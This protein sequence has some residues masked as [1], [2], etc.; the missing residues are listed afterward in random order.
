MNAP[1]APTPEA[2][3]QLLSKLNLPLLTR[4]QIHALV[5]DPEDGQ[6][7][8]NALEC[9]AGDA[10][11]R[12]WLAGAATRAIN[13]VPTSQKSPVASASNA[14]AALPPI[15][16]PLGPP[17]ESTPARQ[18][19]ARPV[20]TDGNVR[21]LRQPQ[22]P[23]DFPRAGMNGTPVRERSPD[24]PTADRADGEPQAA[25]ELKPVRYDQVNA[26][27]KEYGLSIERGPNP[28]RTMN[29]INIAIAKAVGATAKEGLD[30]KQKIMIMLEPFEI[31][32]I[33]A[34]LFDMLPK[35][36]FAG[37]GAAN[38]KWLE[39]ERN[40]GEWASVRFTLAQDK[41]IRR[42][43]VGYTDAGRVKAIFMRALQ[44]QMRLQAN[45][46]LPI[47]KSTALMYQEQTTARAARR[48]SES[49]RAGAR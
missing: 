41:D 4:A 36:R 23:T 24:H 9:A 22:R 2:I 33:A 34:V 29:T 14:A 37:H 6:H 28:E 30:W 47:V 42:V 43:N 44:D 31:E 46:I 27:G 16:D 1:L 18:N 40:T 35:V 25:R 32:L 8:P 10:S 38:D 21:A 26:Y 13:A 19:S 5:N 3:N 15:E 20:A 11:W 48:G 39:V 7:V 45:A 49:Q 12:Q 17:S